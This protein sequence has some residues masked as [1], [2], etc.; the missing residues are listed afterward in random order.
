MNLDEYIEADS[1]DSN[2]FWRLSTGHCQ[3]LLEEA[4]E[5][6]EE[7]QAENKRLQAIVAR[8]SV[9][10]DG[11][12]IAPNDPNT[13]LYYIHPGSG[14]VYA[15]TYVVD[16]MDDRRSHRDASGKTVWIG[17]SDCYVTREA[18]EAVRSP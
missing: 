3:N 16:G 8:L 12:R 17:V 7:L 4:I 11:V 5:R 13:T 14:T 15:R 10:A 9:T 6:C 1:K 18:A 2:T